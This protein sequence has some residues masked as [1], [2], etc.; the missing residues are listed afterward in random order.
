M[1]SIIEAKYL[2]KYKINVIFNDQKS[3]IIDLHDKI[4]YDK[5]AIIKRLK[6]IDTFKAFNLE[7]DTIVWENGYDPAPE[8]L[9]FQAFKDDPDLQEQFKKWGYIW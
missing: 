4:K 2:K 9:Y 6:D 3:S 8:F 7:N 1:L 5:R